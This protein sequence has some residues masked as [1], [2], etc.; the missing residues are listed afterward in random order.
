MFRKPVVTC[1]K[2]D[3]AHATI[4]AKS[5]RDLKLAIKEAKAHLQTFPY[6]AYLYWF[7]HENM[8]EPQQDAFS[9]RAWKRLLSPKV[10][11]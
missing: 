2:S 10:E 8:L 1:A 9:A 3:Y 6:E 11:G 7:L 5:A 4:V